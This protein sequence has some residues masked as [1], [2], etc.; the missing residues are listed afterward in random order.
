MTEANPF[1]AVELIRLAVVAYQCITGNENL[2]TLSPFK[3]II[4]LT[5]PLV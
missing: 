5:K 3:L 4:R 2:Q 1:T